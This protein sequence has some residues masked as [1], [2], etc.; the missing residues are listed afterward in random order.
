LVAIDPKPP[1]YLPSG[2][3]LERNRDLKCIINRV[4]LSQVTQGSIDL[5]LDFVAFGFDDNACPR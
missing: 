2:T 5:L 1:S 3:N 4:R